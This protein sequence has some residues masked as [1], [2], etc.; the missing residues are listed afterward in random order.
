MSTIERNDRPE[1]VAP[2]RGPSLARH[3]TTTQKIV[4][5]LRNLLLIQPECRYSSEVPLLP[6]DLVGGAGAFYLR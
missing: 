2:N 1:G 4:K 5:C 6:Y 3:Y